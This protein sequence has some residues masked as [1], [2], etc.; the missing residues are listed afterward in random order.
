MGTDIETIFE[1]DERIAPY[2]FT[3]YWYVPD[4]GI[5]A[6]ENVVPRCLLTR[7]DQALAV[8]ALRNTVYP[9]APVTAGQIMATWGTPA[10][11][12][13][14]GAANTAFGSPVAA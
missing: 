12:V 5:F 10:A 8:E 3:W 4:V 14:V 9:V 1:Y 2:A 11:Q 7:G 6:S 13:A